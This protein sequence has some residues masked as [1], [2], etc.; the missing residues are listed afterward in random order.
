MDNQEKTFGNLNQEKHKIIDE[1]F[2]EIDNFDK[3]DDVIWYQKNRFLSGK[4]YDVLYLLQQKTNDY[5]IKLQYDLVSSIDK[6][7]KEKNRFKVLS[8][9]KNLK[10]LEM[11]LVENDETMNGQNELNEDDI[12]NQLV[13]KIILLPA[14]TEFTISSLMN[15]NN[16][17]GLK[18]ASAALEKLRKMQIPIKL[19]YNNGLSGLPQNMIYIKLN[20]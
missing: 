3:Y 7:I 6:Y 16:K 15:G 17:H 8:M 9:I 19:K 11:S 2:N 20:K 5:N 18:I 4:L 1:W 10:S 13:D 14:G 12:V